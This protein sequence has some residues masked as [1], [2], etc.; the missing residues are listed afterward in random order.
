[1][2]LRTRGRGDLSERRL[3]HLPPPRLACLI[4]VPSHHAGIAFF[5]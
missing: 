1:M 2:S 3:I 5:S 4:S